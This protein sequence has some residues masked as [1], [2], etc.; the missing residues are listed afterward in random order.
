MRWLLMIS[1]VALAGCTVPIELVH[2][3]TG[4]VRTCGPYPGPLYY[5]RKET[6]RCMADYKEQ[7]YVRR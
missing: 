5:G 2:P 4:E 6:D 1:V 3:K 7:G